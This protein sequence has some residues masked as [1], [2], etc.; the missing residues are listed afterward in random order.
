MDQ[1]GGL[2][3]Y[4]RS[5]NDDQKIQATIRKVKEIATLGVIDRTAQRI[6]LWTENIIVGCRQFLRAGRGVRHFF[7]GGGGDGAGRTGTWVPGFGL[8]GRGAGETPMCLISWSRDIRFSM[9]VMTT[10]DCHT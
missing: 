2:T 6:E 5:K 1:L 10:I 4:A 7:G 8:A 9:Q 3:G